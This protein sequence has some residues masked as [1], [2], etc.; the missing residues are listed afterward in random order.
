M[1]AALAHFLRRLAQTDFDSRSREVG[2]RSLVKRLF[3]KLN[4][5]L[6]GVNWQIPVGL[7]FGHIAIRR[8]NAALLPASPKQLLSRAY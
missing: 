8:A 1:K 5:N 2:T 7:N 6:A 3:I 4:F